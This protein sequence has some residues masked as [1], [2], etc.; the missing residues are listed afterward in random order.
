MATIYDVAKL[1]DVSPKTVSRVLNDEPLVAEE[2]KRKVLEAIH[3]LDYH[4]NAIAA[5]LKRQRSN[6]IGFVVPY[7]SE[8]VFQDMNMMEQLRGA[9]DIVTQAGYDLLISVPVNRQD[10]FEEILRLVRHKNV[11]GVILYPTAGVEPIINE[12]VAKN[13]KYVTLDLF[14]EDQQTNFIN[15]NIWPGVYQATTWLLGHGHRQIGL[16]KKPRAFFNYCVEDTLVAGYQ[17][18]LTENGLSFAEDLVEEGDF[19]FEGGYLAFNKIWQRNRQLSALICASDPMAYGV[20]R[21]VEEQGLRIGEDIQVIAGDDLPLT[22]KLYPFMASITNPG[23]EQ[24]REAGR[25]L[26]SIIHDKRDLPGITLDAGFVVYPP[27]MAST[28]SRD[29]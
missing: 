20:M 29:F 19:T 22:R 10:A 24:G 4:P 18:A 3:Q 2:T 23:Y 25:M 7:G 13:F 15:V 16:I 17:A 11:D 14:R 6:M 26:L 12:L 5:N 9:H 28:L 1:A 27:K 21:A 8:F